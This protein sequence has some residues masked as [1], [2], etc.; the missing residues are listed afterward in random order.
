MSCRRASCPRPRTAPISSQLL[1]G[2]AVL[3]AIEPAVVPHRCPVEVGAPLE[4]RYGCTACLLVR[5]NLADSVRDP[6]QPTPLRAGPLAPSPVAQPPIN[7]GRVVSF[8][9]RKRPC[10]PGNRHLVAGAAP[11]P[12]RA[13]RA[14]LRS[15]KS[16]RGNRPS[17]VAATRMGKSVGRAAGWW[18][19]GAGREDDD[20]G[21]NLGGRVWREI[22]RFDG[23]TGRLRVQINP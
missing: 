3:V 14:G 1:A 8:L 10:R 9:A 13:R 7:L 12:S 23:P 20:G 21:A 4:C 6:T 11:T 22:R 16:R 5:A 15:P 19:P 2:D 17:A 18:R